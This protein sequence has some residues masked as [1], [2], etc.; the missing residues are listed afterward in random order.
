MPATKPPA[1]TDADF[2]E[3]EIARR[4]DDVARRMLN[5]PYKPQAP[6][7]DADASKPK[8]KKKAPAKA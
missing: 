5:T 3:E 7:G 2:T 1:D 4:R 8:K 6:K